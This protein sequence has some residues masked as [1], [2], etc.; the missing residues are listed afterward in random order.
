MTCQHEWHKNYFEGE[1][2]FRPEVC[3]K[4]GVKHPDWIKDEREQQ[5][6]EKKRSAAT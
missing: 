5:E 2:P 6:R 3:I 1:P 4:C